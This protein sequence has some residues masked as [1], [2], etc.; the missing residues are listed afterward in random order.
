MTTKLIY[1]IYFTA[2]DLINA[3][4]ENALHW[5]DQRKNIERNAS[6]MMYH[7]KQY[8]DQI[9]ADYRVIGI[10]PLFEEFM[11]IVRQAL[12]F[13]NDYQALQHYKHYLME[14]FTKEYDEVL[15]V[16][17]DVY[18]NTTL[19]IFDQFDLSQGVGIH[20]FHD[21]K[22][23]NIDTIHAGYINYL[24]T[25]RSAVTKHALMISLCVQHDTNLIPQIPVFNT[26]IMLSNDQLSTQINY[27][28][29]LQ[30]T[31]IEIDRIKAQPRHY[32]ADYIQEQYTYNNESIFS[33]LVHRNAVPINPL[34]NWHFVHNHRNRSELIP[35]DANLVHLISKR[36]DLVH[37]TH[38]EEL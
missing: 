31:R 11:Q 23:E 28:N 25:N 34:Y 32:F 21:D 7:Q 35:D 29:S 38:I 3:G 16:D 24:P 12:I 6:L 4:F 17:L 27:T 36:F 18:P 2:D 33:Y 15:Y 1:T 9:N 14:K 37:N 20:G 13:D 26:G 10:G 30:D 19:S 22:Q 8:A 5:Y